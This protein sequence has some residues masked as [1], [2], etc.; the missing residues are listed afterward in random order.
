MPVFIGSPD[1]NRSSLGAASRWWLHNSLQSLQGDLRR[2]GSRLVIRIGEPLAELR[3][4]IK[5]SGAEAVCWNRLYETPL[6]E[7]DRRIKSAI[8]EAG[9]EVHSFNSSLL[10]EPWDVLTKAG[11]PYQVFTP[12]W[13]ACLRDTEPELPEQ[14]PSMIPAFDDWPHSE[15]LEALALKPKI[16]WAAGLRAAWR[17]GTSG[18]EHY[19]DEFLSTA[20]PN[21]RD[22][23]NRPDLIGTSRL[24][25]HI[26]FGEIGPRQIWH[27]MAE[28]CTTDRRTRAGKSV[29]AFRS[30]LGWREFSHHVLFHFP[31]TTGRPLREQFAR[32]PWQQDRHGLR[33]WQR[34]QTGYPIVDAGM[35]ELWVTGWMHN[36]VRMIVGSFLTKDLLISWKAGAHWFWDTLVDADLA[37]NTLG[38][39]WVAGCGAD[40]A[41]YFRVFNPVTQ[42][43]KFDPDGK[44]VRRWVPELERMPAR[45]I[46]EPWAAP[47]NVLTQAGVTPGETYPH[48]IVDHSKARKS[49][50]AA[51]ERI[52]DQ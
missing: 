40:A 35:R 8:R 21:Y 51:F 47:S 28:R 24:S 41:P 5:E 9:L 38:W 46:H 20:I 18:A 17:P 50:L 48:Q 36:R 10:F 23:R 34:G 3:R 12:F 22:D 1:G 33:R 14:A 31:K 19:L 27:K 42:G 30:Q 15:P 16:D 43:K 7:R 45:W 44:Y 4:L 37:N 25:P 32:F 26:H 39:Q 13:K 2:L 11:L 29:A 52:R 6:M 49:A